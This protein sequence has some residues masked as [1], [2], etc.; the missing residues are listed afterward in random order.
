MRNLIL[1]VGLFV[2][3]A[4]GWTNAQMNAHPVPKPALEAKTVAVVNNTHND[5]VTEGAIEALKRWGR[6][7]IVDDS[8]AADLTLTFDKKSEHEGT[9]TQKKGDDGKTDSGYSV[10]FSTSIHM[11]ATLKGS[12]TSFY[13]TTTGE[14]KKKAGAG[15]ILDLQRIYL[16]SPR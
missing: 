16:A 15:C 2:F 3:G 7:T 13:S 10:S 1:G 4:A 14:S 8:D 6:F 11:K 9:S 12:E 5:A